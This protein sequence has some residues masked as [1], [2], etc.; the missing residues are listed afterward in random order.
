MFKITLAALTTAAALAAA[1]VL[2][3]ST[4]EI[5]ATAVS[6]YV[7]DFTL[8][9]E[10]LDGDALFSM[11]EL[12]TFSGFTYYDTTFMSELRAAPTLDGLADGGYTC[13]GGLPAW[14][15]YP[16]SGQ[17]YYAI[18]APAW[19]YS[20]TEQPAAVPLP[21]AGLMLAGG[22][23]GLGALRLRRKAIKP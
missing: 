5:E 12:L 10:D 11:D 23:S 15:V 18:D 20:L 16:G 2:A 6:Q 7:T 13:C 22:L 14:A 19:T 8:T 1:P 4:Y 21:A 9:F 3:A 17:F